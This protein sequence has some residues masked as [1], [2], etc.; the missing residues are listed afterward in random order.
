MV[1][2]SLRTSSSVP[3]KSVLL[4]EDANS[5]IPSH[6]TQHTALHGKY[7]KNVLNACTDPGTCGGAAN[8][9]HGC[10]GH[11]HTGTANHTHGQG[12]G[13]HSATVQSLVVAPFVGAPQAL[14]P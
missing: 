13:T 4:W 2:I 3:I 8:H 1:S 9:T 12:V 11:L 6:F 14:R 5:L 7:A 10:I